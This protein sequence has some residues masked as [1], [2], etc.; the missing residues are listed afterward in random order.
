MQKDWIRLLQVSMIGA[1]ISVSAPAIFAEE[2]IQDD[3]NRQV[4]LSQMAKYPALSK[5]FKQEI[6]TNAHPRPAPSEGENLFL[7]QLEDYQKL[8]KE[9][10]DTFAQNVAIREMPETAEEIYLW[11]LEDYKELDKTFY[12]EHRKKF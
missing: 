9:F 7:W 3:T 12:N 8:N 1:A 2:K 5:E 6:K 4:Y 11:Q 10:A